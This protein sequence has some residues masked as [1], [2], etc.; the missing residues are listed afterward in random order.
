MV[1]PPVLAVA[2]VFAGV[3]A[4]TVAGLIMTENKE[5]Q[6]ESVRKENEKLTEALAKVAIRREMAMRQVRAKQERE[7]K[8]L[9]AIETEGEAVRAA[10]LQNQQEVAKMMDRV[11]KHDSSDIVVTAKKNKANAQMLLAAGVLVLLVLLK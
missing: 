6:K 7:E 11:A 5:A 8:L 1:A 2:V 3:A 4:T 10:A 9:G